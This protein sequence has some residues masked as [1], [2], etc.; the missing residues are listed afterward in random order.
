M[1]SE[2][3]WS[4]KT[5]EAPSAFGSLERRDKRRVRTAVAEERGSVVFFFSYSQPPTCRLPWPLLSG[6][7]GRPPCSGSS[8]CGCGLGSVAA[9]PRTVPCSP[10]MGSPRRR[11]GGC[12]SGL[13]GQMH[14]FDDC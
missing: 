5:S 7:C 9:H 4:Q 2:E 3:F 14:I 11:R 13:R 10:P 12:A 8:G 1:C 6:C